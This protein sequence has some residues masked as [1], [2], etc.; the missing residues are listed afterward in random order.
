ML[1][2]ILTLRKEVFFYIFFQKII[3]NVYI[4]GLNT[5][6]SGFIVFIY[7]SISPKCR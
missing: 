1:N 2:D 6:Y 3:V 7:I 5:R 4:F